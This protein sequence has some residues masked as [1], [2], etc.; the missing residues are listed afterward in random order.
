MAKHVTQKTGTT[1]EIEAI[2]TALTACPG[3]MYRS[4]NEN[5]K[6]WIGLDDGSLLGPLSTETTPAFYGDYPDD[7]TAGLNGV[8]LGALYFLTPMNGYDLAGGSVKK[9]IEQ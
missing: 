1:A 3:A 6:V 9:R 8:P 2:G 4:T 5:R 7:E